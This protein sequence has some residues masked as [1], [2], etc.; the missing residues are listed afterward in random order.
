[1]A[2]S[3]SP[4]QVAE[5]YTIEKQLAR[6][7]LLA[8]RDAR[9]HLYR[10]LYDELFRRVPHHTQLTQKASPERSLAMV[11]RQL[12]F[13]R[14]F[15]GPGR[16][17]LE[18]GPGDCALSLAVAPLAKRVYAVD[19]SEEITR[20]SHHPA[21]FQLILSDGCSIPVPARTI[22]IAYSNQLMEHLHP[23]D[24]LEQLR[25]VYTAL[26]PGGIYIC[27][28]PNAVNGP[29][30]V[31]AGFDRVATGFHLKEYRI[32]ELRRLFLEV[33]FSRVQAYAEAGR[34][35]RVPIASLLAFESILAA[36]PYRIR[37]AIGRNL[38]FRLLLGRPLVACK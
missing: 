31:S 20:A 35:I 27:I 4:A 18:I 19:V 2:D 10:S 12:R 1:M 22:D 13:L 24:A 36:L 29:H 14:R 16:S 37:V 32:A 21:N 7:L 3:R 15:L 33:G 38:P 6:Q 8:P 26:K 30:D 9:R 34:L 5:H 11:E 23:D 17:F 25:N 28:T